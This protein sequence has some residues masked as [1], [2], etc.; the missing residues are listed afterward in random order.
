VALQLARCLQATA[1]VTPGASLLQRLESVRLASTDLDSSE[2]RLLA[3][4]L[5]AA[6]LW[7]SDHIPD[8]GL[9]DTVAVVAGLYPAYT[10]GPF[11][12]LRQYDSAELRIRT[13]R[14]R[15]RHAGSFNVP[16]GLER[17]LE[18]NPKSR[19]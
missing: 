3:G 8:T 15:A 17:L 7:C 11:N 13:Q 19:A 9:A 2:D 5:A 6:E 10:G 14:A 18:H 4:A 1:I 16:D 12:Y